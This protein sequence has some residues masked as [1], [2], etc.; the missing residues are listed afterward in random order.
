MLADA[1]GDMGWIR[2]EMAS[3]RRISLEQATGNQAAILY[4][5]KFLISFLQFLKIRFRK[6]SLEIEK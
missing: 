2:G 1:L 6:V 3:P 5:L 4:F